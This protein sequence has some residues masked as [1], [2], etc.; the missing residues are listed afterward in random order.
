[1]YLECVCVEDLDGA[2]QQRHSQQS[3]V[4]GELHTQ[5]VFLQLQSARVFHRQPPV[6]HTHTHTNS[7]YSQN[8][9]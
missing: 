1:M 2:I 4:R 3:V 9:L 6:S 8:H 5:D 7:K